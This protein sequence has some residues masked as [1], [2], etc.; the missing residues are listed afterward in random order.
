MKKIG[1]YISLMFLISFLAFL[2]DFSIKR[3]QNK[4]IKKVEVIFL[5]K[6]NNYLTHS[7]V[8]KMLIQEKDSV[9]LP[10]KGKLNLQ[11]LNSKL[12][13]NPYVE[14][15]TVFLT[16]DGLLK[17]NI[18][19]RKPI[20]RIVDSYGA[21]YV[22]KFAKLMPLSANYSAR[23][24][25]VSG[26]ETQEEV[27]KTVQ[28]IEAISKDEFLLKEVV[29]IEKKTKNNYFFK[30]RSGDYAVEFGDLKNV[31][32]KLKKLKAFY[33]KAFVDKSIN[34]YKKINIKYNNQVV[35]KK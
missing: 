7:M 33:N 23:V 15:A 16:I 32:Q 17:T 2:Y 3:S 26:L 35:C 31:E 12:L 25:L 4:E 5:G 9:K 8:S 1:I 19:Q 18:K 24:M 14:K 11:Q 13:S 21:Y 27:I 20:A 34:K 28:L 29:A 22:D 30:V 10:K 6:G